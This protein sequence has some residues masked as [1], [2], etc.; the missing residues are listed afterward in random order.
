MKI[1]SSH[2]GAGTRVP[3]LGAASNKPPLSVYIM[4]AL[5]VVRMMR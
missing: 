2:S 5:L 1:S 4:M 3:F